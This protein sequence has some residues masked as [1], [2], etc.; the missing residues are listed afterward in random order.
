EA[1]LSTHTLE[2]SRRFNPICYDDDDDYDYKEST[3]HLN[4]INSKIP[5]S[6]V[7]TTSPPVLPTEDPKDSF[8]MGNEDL[9]TIL[10]K[11][12]D[13]F[14]KSNVEDLVPIL[15]ESED[16][17]GTESVC[18]LPWCDDFSPIN[19]P[20]EKTVTFSNPLFNSNDDFISSD[21]ESLSNKDVQEDNVKIYSNPLFEF[22]DEY[23]YS[24]INSLF[25]EV[26][27]KI[28]CKDSYDPNLD[29]STFLD[30][31]LSDSNED[32]YFTLGD[33]AELL[34]HHDPS[35]P[36][37]SIASIL[38]GFTDETPLKKNDELFDLDSKNDD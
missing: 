38:E 29:E 33:D 1:K 20:K 24:D 12:L 11:E 30:T 18:I 37:M 27:E 13:E 15:S 22:D 8:I 6:I 2:P 10:E 26:L 31:P 23:I 4:E 19:V 3:I 17:F 7:I 25:D 14:I 35:I 21:D 34:L 5:P 36:K 9:N 32:E 28:E 16:T